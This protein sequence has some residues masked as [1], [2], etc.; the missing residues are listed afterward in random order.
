M[1]AACLRRFQNGSGIGHRASGIGRRK[2]KA[3][4]FV[5]CAG[6]ALL[7]STCVWLP[8]VGVSSASAQ[9][10]PVAESGTTTTSS[11]AAAV[12][13]SLPG[14]S[15]STSAPPLVS[16]VQSASST[17]PT[18]ASTPVTS[19]SSASSTSA[20]PSLN[21]QTTSVSLTSSTLGATTPPGGAAQAVRPSLT[22]SELAALDLRIAAENATKARSSL[23]QANTIARMA[24]PFASVSVPATSNV[25][26]AGM[27]IPPG[28][29]TSPPVVVVEGGS[30]YSIE[31]SGLVDCCARAPQIGPDGAPQNSRVGPA[32]GISRIESTR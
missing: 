14:T 25:F 1:R 17:V 32:G 30:S 8:E 12:T 5:L 11:V 3:Q 2:A 21:G 15:S 18:P 9:N 4:P 27:A 10:L 19:T 13:T 31:A 24:T 22:S 28:G 26:G 20:L 23:R 7:F 16:V 29:G 6:S